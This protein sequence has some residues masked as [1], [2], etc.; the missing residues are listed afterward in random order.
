MPDHNPDENL[1]EEDA[2]R[3]KDT[4]FDAAINGHLNVGQ[5]NGPEAFTADLIRAV[6]LIRQASRTS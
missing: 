5:G 2:K 4:V 6:G 3:I 1:S